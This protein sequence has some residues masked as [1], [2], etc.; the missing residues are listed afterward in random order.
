MAL[1]KQA[2]VETEQK[3]NGAARKFMDTFHAYNNSIGN[4]LVI[5]NENDIKINGRDTEIDMLYRVMERPLTPIAILIGEAGVGK[6]AI[7]KEFV[8]QLNSGEY[9]TKLNYD[10]FA[11]SLRVG[12]LSALGNAK[13]QS[14]L[15]NLFND[16]ARF[17]K[18]AQ[19]VLQNKN[20]RIVLFIDEVHMLVTIFGPGTKVGGDVMKDVLTPAPI[21]VITATTRREYDSTIATDAPFAQRLKLIQ[22]SELNKQTVEQI[23]LKWWKDHAPEQKPLHV[24]LIR[25]IIAA[26]A[27]YR[28]DSAEPRKTID[29][30]EDLVSYSRITGLVPSEETVDQI[31]R[32]RYSINLSFSVSADEIYDEIARRVKGQEHAKRALKRAF[33]AMV[34]QLD[35]N[36][37]RPR[38]CYL[39]TG[40]TGVG[41]TETVKAIAQAMHH[42]SR[43][44]L[45][46]INMPDYKTPEHEPAFRKYLGEALRHSPNRIVLLDEMEKA[47]ETVLDSLLVILDEGNVTFETLNRENLP[48]VN[49][50]SLR[51]SLIIATTNAGY[52]VFNNDAKYSQKDTDG[53]TEESQRAEI[54]QL[55]NS[56]REHLIASGFKPE[57][58]GRFSRIV[59][60][61]GLSES[62]LLQ[63]AEMK[64]DKLIR[65]F[66]ELKGIDIILNEPRQW[67]A[68]KYNYFTTD[69][70][71]DITFVRAKADD[72]SSGGARAIQREID[73]NLRDEIIDAII[74]N[75]GCT[76]FKLEVSKSSRIYDSSA[77]RSEKGV[78]VYAIKD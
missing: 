49:T 54:R 61:R 74:D 4:A 65:A 70:A 38:D 14:V 73:D 48:E 47:H 52:E 55:Q 40:P 6:T 20:L 28:S 66:K 18:M 53:E 76:K 11:L 5:L 43:D 69:V 59:P 34:F 1:Q 24:D 77:D 12:S 22:I 35:P 10:Y 36:S 75:E 62:E 42:G 51:N 33:R 32:D 31:F 46:H 68:D 3:V 25:K 27:A 57:L 44:A 78:Y 21:R 23:C 9:R 7:A 41:K 16:L 8:R 29:L 63:I 13:I 56:L 50:I 19:Q 15:S 30:L 37:N 71:L 58:L 45:L 72:P 64:I 17:E 60:Y 67:P 26:N 2:M 39:F